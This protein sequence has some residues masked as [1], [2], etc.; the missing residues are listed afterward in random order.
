MLELH[1]HLHV[2]WQDWLW[3]WL[4]LEPCHNSSSL[5]WSE[6]LFTGYDI[7]LSYTQIVIHFKQVLKNDKLEVNIFPID[8]CRTELRAMESRHARELSL[9]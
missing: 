6:G 8:I 1:S 4:I 5:A 9:Q 2:S 7:L 3:L